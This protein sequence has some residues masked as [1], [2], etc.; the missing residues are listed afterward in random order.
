MFGPDYITW[1]HSRG[2][3]DNEPDITVHT[4]KFRDDSSILVEARR[5]QGCG[6]EVIS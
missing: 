2:C 3:D 6:V 4:I 5:G 1:M